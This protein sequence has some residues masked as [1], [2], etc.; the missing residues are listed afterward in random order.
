MERPESCSI[1]LHLRPA[2]SSAGG[3]H[4]VAAPV[5]A[6]RV[7]AALAQPVVLP[8]LVAAAASSTLWY[9]TMVVCPGRFGM[10]HKSVDNVFN[11]LT[12]TLHSNVSRAVAL[13]A[14]RNRVRQCVLE[15]RSVTRRR[16]WGWSCD[17]ELQRWAPGQ[18]GGGGTMVGFLEG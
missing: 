6:H 2:T 18:G 13:T 1:A 10:T 12:D 9:L 7:V 17:V 14:R 5:P 4:A 15:K 11:D 3:L 16:S 8:H